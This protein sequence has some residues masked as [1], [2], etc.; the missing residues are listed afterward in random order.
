MEVIPDKYRGTK[1]YMLV[2][3]ELLKAARYGGTTT[4]QAVAQIL[5]LP[6]TGSYM[7]REV[8]HMVGEISEDEFNHGRPMLS[9][10]VVGVSGRPG[11]GFFDL[12]RQLGKLTEE[13]EK[14][15]TRFWEQEKAAV[16][17]TWRREFE[18]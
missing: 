6:S 3:C 9:S 16:Y 11:G 8:G 2:F 15:E 12:A 13:S 10:V 18:A 4:Y 14:A 7:G 1:E 17:H 5:S